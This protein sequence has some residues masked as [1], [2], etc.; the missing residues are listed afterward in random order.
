MPVGRKNRHA[1]IVTRGGAFSV[2]LGVCAAAQ[3]GH[4]G[5][6]HKKWHHDFYATLKRTDGT[7]SC[8]SDD[9]Y[10]PTVSRKVG[11]H[12]EIKVDGRPCRVGRL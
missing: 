9:D 11:G 10:R 2:L 6:D 1:F 8:C 3:E 7:G 4:Y 5:V 12:R